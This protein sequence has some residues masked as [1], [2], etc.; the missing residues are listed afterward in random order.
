[1]EGGM[2]RP[3]AARLRSYYWEERAMA[4]A[5]LSRWRRRQPSGL[6]AQRLLA[7]G[8]GC[9]YVLTGIWPV[10][11]IDT[12]QAVTGRKRDVWLVKTA[13]LLIA[14]IGSALMLAG[15]GGK[16]SPEVRVLAV[17][18]SVSLAGIDLVYVWR[19]QIG[20]I[21]LADAAGELT[22]ATMWLVASRGS[23]MR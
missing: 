7:G 8:H 9:Y 6:D 13:G 15:C 4:S 11:S 23:A 5:F 14:S 22:L 21:Y 2:G 17:T 20:P 12:F 16:I 19:R 18:S 3:S 10:L 1:M